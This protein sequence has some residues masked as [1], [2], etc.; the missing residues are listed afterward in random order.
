VIANTV[1]PLDPATGAVGQA[2]QVAAGAVRIAAGFGALWVT[3]TTNV[4][5]EVQPKAV[6]TAAVVYPITVGQIPI[7]VATGLG[8][9]WV[10]NSADGTVSQIDPKT[11][12]VLQTLPTGGKNPVAVAVAGGRVWVADANGAE[13]STVYPIPSVGPTSITGSPRSIVPV[14]GG[15]WVT[16]ATPP[17]VY[18]ATVSG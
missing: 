3:G 15:V 9:V 14:G 6:G 8:S 1:T 17:R 2:V 16:T 4:V 11:R 5:T 7:G 10:G 12:Q 13:L 18:D